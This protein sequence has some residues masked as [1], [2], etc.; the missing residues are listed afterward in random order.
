MD[1]VADQYAD[2][3]HNCWAFVAGPPGSTAHVGMSDAGE[4]QGTA[5]RPMLTA[6]LHGG[7]GEIVAVVTRYYGGVKLGKGGLGRA[8]SGSVQAA[9]ESLPVVERVLRTEVGLEFEYAFVDPVLQSL[10]EVEALRID[11]EYG[12]AVRFRVAVPEDR[13]EGLRQR[14]AEITAGAGSFRPEPD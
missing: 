12:V 5:G 9:L 2:A 1:A 10:D 11:E 14:F 4:P 3:T 6:L 8:Y 7:V 13:L